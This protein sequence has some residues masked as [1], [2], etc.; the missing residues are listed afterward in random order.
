MSPTI[1]ADIGA[2]LDRKDIPVFGVADAGLLNRTAPAGFRPEDVLPGAR[3]VLI[4]ARPLPLSIFQTPRNGR[5]YSF[6]SSA[7]HA[8]YQA[9]NEAVNAVCLMIGYAGHT[10]LPIPSYS[11]LKFHDGEPRGLVSLK[12]AAVAAGL[13]KMGKNTLLIHPREGN[14]LRLGGL[15]TTLDLPADGPGDFPNLCPPGCRK[16]LEAC[17]VGALSEKGID[18]MQCMGNCIEHLLM[19]P[20]WFLSLLRWPVSKSRFLTDVIDLFA[21]SFFQSY[22]ISCFACLT[23]CPFFPGNRRVEPEKAH[24][25][26]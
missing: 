10:A 13:G 17:P 22:G 8:Y 9:T 16:C 12:H 25:P 18:K 4:V 1:L 19:P 5:I 3:S 15:V 21:L 7:F 14:I 11:P 23:A 20:R 6:Y 2:A 26:D 24:G